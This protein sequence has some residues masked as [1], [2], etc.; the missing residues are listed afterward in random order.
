MLCQRLGDGAAGAVT[1][2]PYVHGPCHRYCSE[3]VIAGAHIG[4][5][6]GAP[7]ASIPTFDQGLSDGE[8]GVITDRPRVTGPHHSHSIEHVITVPQVVAEDGEPYTA[9]PMLN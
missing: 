2:C 6:D 5:G 4:A 8:V 9:I 7:V 3:A 1:Y